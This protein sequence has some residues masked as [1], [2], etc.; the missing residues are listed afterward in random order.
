MAHASIPNDSMANPESATPHGESIDRQRRSIIVAAGAAAAMT[1]AGPAIANASMQ[2]QRRVLWAANVR[3]KSFEDRIRVAQIGGFS[4]M[5]VFPIDYRGWRAQ[6][7][8]PAVMR[9]RLRAAGLRIIAID[10]FVQWTPG[11]A[12]PAA[13]PKENVGFIDFSEAQILEIASELEAE[14]VNCVEGLGQAHEIAVLV[15]RFGAFADRAKARGLRVTLEFMPISSITGLAE[16]WAIV[17]GA[18]RDNAGLCFDTWHYFRSKP[19]DALLRTIPGDK[20]FEVQLADALNAL[21][22]NDLI[23][24]LLRFRRLPGEGEMPIARVVPILHAMGAWRSVG[25]EVFADAMDRLSV[26]EAGRR[27]GA[28]VDRWSAAR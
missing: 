19:D 1:M 17:S 11:F 25:P 23:D 12:I 28:A 6:G 3:G 18:N 15:E 9:Q 26:E 20:I 5:S 24:D 8:T 21:Q 4:H 22:G 7:L 14:G 10:P 13:Y 16:G 2:P 27:C